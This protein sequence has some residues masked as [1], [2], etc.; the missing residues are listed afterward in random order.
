MKSLCFRGFER[1]TRFGIR[2]KPLCQFE[3]GSWANFRDIGAIIIRRL[4][5]LRQL[6]KLSNLFCSEGGHK[7]PFVKGRRKSF[8]HISGGRGIVILEG[9]GFLGGKMS[10]FKKRSPE[11]F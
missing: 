3:L 7:T 8:V 11:S 6:R 1:A 9:G 2:N 10:S 5:S 4:G